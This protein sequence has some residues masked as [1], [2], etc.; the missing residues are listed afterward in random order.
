M[1]RNLRVIL[2]EDLPTVGQTGELVKV[3]PGFARNFLIPRG[4]AVIAT[5]DNVSKLEHDRRV[6]ELRAAKLRSEAEKVAAEIA[7]AK[8]SIGCPVGEGDKLYGSVGAR[9]VADALSEQGIE[10][11]RR[12]IIMEP[13]KE[14][15]VHEVQIKIA[16]GVDA[17]VNVEVVP[18]A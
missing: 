17:T 6:A 4:L 3:R 14:L 15:G 1:A 11:D 7:K 2:T 8:V 10:I 13:I 18:K 9:D 5:T 12:K 16:S